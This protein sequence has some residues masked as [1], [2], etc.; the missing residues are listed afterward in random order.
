MR[1]RSIFDSAVAAFY[2]LFI[3]GLATVGEVFE[4]FDN[5][6]RG[7]N[8]HA[9]LIEI[10]AKYAWLICGLPALIILVA[11]LYY[12]L[13]SSQLTLWKRIAWSTALFFAMPLA[14]PM[15]WWRYKRASA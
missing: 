13:S 14:V 5:L 7:A 10:F 3:L 9:P 12:A 1:L 15:Y 8:T 4:G 6:V 2:P 11:Y